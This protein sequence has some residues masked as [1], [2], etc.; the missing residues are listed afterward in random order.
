LGGDVPRV[1]VDN[2]IPVAVEI[3]PVE[4]WQRV[5]ER[6][7][8]RDRIL[9]GLPAHLLVDVL[10]GEAAGY[11]FD[12][13]GLLGRV[14]RRGREVDGKPNMD[15][16]AQHDD[17]PHRRVAKVL[18]DRPPLRRI[19]VPLVDVWAVPIRPDELD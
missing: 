10:R 18:E 5:D 8:H 15:I 14:E 3:D 2:D 19:A 16:A 11:E 13:D 1:N 9:P 7:F 12:R 17:V 4:M 6:T